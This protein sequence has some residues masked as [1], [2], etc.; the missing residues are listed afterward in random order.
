MTRKRSPQ[1]IVNII[2]YHKKN[3]R[4]HGLGETF[5]MVEGESDEELWNKFCPKE[6]CELFSADGKDNIIAAL[7]MIND[8]GDT[9]VAGIV[10]AD[11]WLIR[12]SDKLCQDNLLYDECYPDTE[13]MILNSADSATLTD[14]FRAG[15]YSQDDPEI[16]R[17]AD[18]LQ[19]EAER[20]AMEF[21]YF[22]L[23]NDC[24]RYCISFRDFWESRRYDYDE[25]LDVEDVESIQFRQECF[26]K[27]LADFHNAGKSLAHNKRIEDWEL[28]EGVAKLK[29]IDKFKTPNVQLCQGHETI[30]IVANLLPVMFKSVFG[31]NP[32]PMFNELRN[33]LNLEKKLRNKYTKEDFVTT[34]LCESIRNWE[35]DDPCYKILAEDPASVIC[36]IRSPAVRCLMRSE[37]IELISK[38]VN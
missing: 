7:D 23:L 5:V 12:K 6:S 32:P 10:D 31:S 3:W 15:F 17:F 27:R 4:T 33:R 38:S 11:Y 30:A 20:L 18:L 2:H 22:R 21:G 29:K 36:S 24:K 35:S 34:T 19:T 1:A 28:L 26:A 14:V 37:S 25:F 9:G 8:R 13:L 16:Q